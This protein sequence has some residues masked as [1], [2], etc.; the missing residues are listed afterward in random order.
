MHFAPL[1]CDG[2]IAVSTVVLALAYLLLA[3][4]PEVSEAEHKQ[5]LFPYYFRQAAAYEFFL[6]EN[7]AQRLLVKEQPVLTWTNS[8]DKYMGGVF[9]WTYDGRPEVVGCIGS[10]QT[11]AGECFVFH[12]LHSLS[13]AAIQPVE[14]GGGPRVWKPPAIAVELRLVEGAPQPADTERERLTQ[15]RNLAREFTGW[16]KHEGDVTELRLLPQPIFRYTAPQQ[17]ILDGTLFAFVCKG[18]DPDVVLLLE[19]RKNK[20][21]Q[22]WHYAFV[23]FNW[24]QLWV[25]RHNK[26]VWRVAQSGLGNTLPFI[27]GR[28]AQ[29]TIEAIRNMASQ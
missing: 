11:D 23:R 24:C 16:M 13:A 1:A 10:R 15:M 19:S 22:A 26:E 27:S 28:I 20:D 25:T 3:Q 2:F 9:L 8:A 5:I 14:F 7:R 18:T 4:S 12:E 6:D 29:T 17:D 21:K